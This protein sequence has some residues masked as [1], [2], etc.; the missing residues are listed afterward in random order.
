MFQ[1]AIF[2]GVSLL[3]GYFYPM[4][5][6]LPPFLESG[7]AYVVERDE[8]GRALSSFIPV[9]VTGIQPTQV[10]GLEKTLSP[11]GR[12]SAGSL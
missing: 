2:I 8:N 12:A 1:V 6:R 5:K 9:L 11:R 4:Q 3:W 10:L 7:G